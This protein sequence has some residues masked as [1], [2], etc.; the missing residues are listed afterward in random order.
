M[1]C[2]EDGKA[3]A[4]FEKQLLDRIAYLESDGDI[5]GQTPQ[6]ERHEFLRFV[7]DAARKMMESIEATAKNEGMTMMDMI[8]EW[9]LRADSF[10]KKWQVCELQS[11][12][13]V[14]ATVFRTMNHD[15]MKSFVDFCEEIEKDLWKDLGDWLKMM[16]SDDLNKVLLRRNGEHQQGVLAACLDMAWQAEKTLTQDDLLPDRSVSKLYEAMSRAGKI[17]CALVHRDVEIESVPL[18]KLAT[19]M[20]AISFWAS[21]TWSANAED[22]CLDDIWRGATM[23][24]PLAALVR[25]RQLGAEE[26]TSFRRA[27]GQFLYFIESFFA[28]TGSIQSAQ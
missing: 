23:L 9:S 28:T 25:N 16:I 13:Q 2:V 6:E 20:M 21:K 8:G 5:S 1:I 18:C 12:F 19:K 7:L 3:A 22:N 11:C 27:V 15:D 17:I 4:T 26:A 14:L 24:H 10:P